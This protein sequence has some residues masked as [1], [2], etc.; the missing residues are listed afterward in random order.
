MKK[1]FYL[2]FV[3]IF[4]LI[5]G[6]I[7][8]AYAATTAAPA[9]SDS[10]QI[11]IESQ[12][13]FGSKIGTGLKNEDISGNGLT[14]DKSSSNEA[15][16]GFE[17]ADSSLTIKGV[18]FENI[19]STYHA[20]KA[21]ITLDNW[22]R[23]KSADF[24][25][26]EKGGTYTFNGKKMVVP[27]NSHVT[28]D[29][30]RGISVMQPNDSPLV[31][32]EILKNSKLGE[33]SGASDVFYSGTNIHLDNGNVLNEGQILYQGGRT[34][35]MPLSG[36]SSFTVDGATIKDEGKVAFYQDPSQARV[37]K[38]DY[39]YVNANNK[40][41]DFSLSDP[42]KSSKRSLLIYDEQSPFLGSAPGAGTY[43]SKK[44]LFYFEG[45]TGTDLKIDGRNT[46]KVAG[47][48]IDYPLIQPAAQGDA[49]WA[50][51]QGGVSVI[52]SDSLYYDPR[53]QP[54]AKQDSMGTTTWF[55]S[56]VERNDFYLFYEEGDTPFINY[57]KS[58]VEPSRIP[59]KM[60]VPHPGVESGATA[61]L[62]PSQDVIHSA[63]EIATPPVL[64]VAEE[65]T[66]VV[67]APVYKVDPRPPAPEVIQKS[68]D[69]GSPITDS[70]GA[71]N[72]KNCYVG[73]NVVPGNSQPGPGGNL[74]GGSESNF[75]ESYKKYIDVTTFS[76]ARLDYMLKSQRMTQ[77]AYDAIKCLRGE[78]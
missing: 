30:V 27:G 52:R 9:A 62:V 69:S 21:E 43:T 10:E 1:L 36:A 65:P 50:I 6:G 8:F 23:I 20:E 45:N 49:K 14:I 17:N 54:L 78:K 4:V 60:S 34:Y 33:T 66:V 56:A 72:S 37:T 74:I 32:P 29:P 35:V 42:G 15:K 3:F 26:N 22:G 41:I 67:S 40:Q 77:T 64:T 61:F 18:K 12:Q 2:A 46:V 68:L 19:L 57:G 73:L 55:K 44:G 39:L 71:G 13:N 38:E 48:T 53:Q 11:S 51:Q 16:I 59:K 58:T 28:Y 24:Y 31:K 63:P 5:L 70:A 7:Y 25:T 76:R 75:R 47:S